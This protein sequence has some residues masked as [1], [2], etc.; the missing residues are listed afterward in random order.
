MEDEELIDLN[1]FCSD[2]V[3]SKRWEAFPMHLLKGKRVAEWV[4]VREVCL[5]AGLNVGDVKS[6]LFA[7]WLPEPTGDEDYALILFYDEESMWTMAARYNR[8][9]I[10]EGL[11]RIMAESGVYRT[12]EQGRPA[13]SD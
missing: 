9:R 1:N 11:P 2:L 3:G 7:S 5:D 13:H 4:R 6:D 10:R 8:Q 12:L